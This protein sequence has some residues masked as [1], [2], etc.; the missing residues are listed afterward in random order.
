MLFAVM[1]AC[2][3]KLISTF[4]SARWSIIRK[5]VD[6]SIFVR[7]VDVINKSLVG[8]RFS[9]VCSKLVYQ[10]PRVIRD[11]WIVIP[12]VGN[13]LGRVSVDRIGL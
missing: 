6:L 3:E 10:L 4:R 13:V 1:T 7:C 12:T 5:L 2:T 9:G 11:T 8:P